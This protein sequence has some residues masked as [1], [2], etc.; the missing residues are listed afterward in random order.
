MALAEEERR[1][2]QQIYSENFVNTYNYK[3]QKN[4][5]LIKNIKLQINYVEELEKES[6]IEHKQRILIIRNR[7]NLAKKWR[8]QI[9]IH[10]EQSIYLKRFIRKTGLEYCY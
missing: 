7:I 2:M 4:E 5:V 10:K 9:Q 8:K 1:N 6:D 3:L